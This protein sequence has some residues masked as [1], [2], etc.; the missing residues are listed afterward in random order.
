MTLD[1]KAREAALK[2]L[3]NGR[4][5][6]QAYLV[7]SAADYR[8]GRRTEPVEPLG[9]ESTYTEF[10]EA[11]GEHRTVMLQNLLDQEIGLFSELLAA[12]E[13]EENEAVRLACRKIGQM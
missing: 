8:L 3:S 11:T 5:D 9:L 1:E 2:S 7:L 4:F 6:W 12:T 13:G 10:A